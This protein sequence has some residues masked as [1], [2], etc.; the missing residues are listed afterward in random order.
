MLY[1]REDFDFI[2]AHCHFFPPQIFKAI[3]DFFEKTD[4]NGA[5]QGWSIKYKLSTK[6]L[7]SFLETHSVKAFTTYNYAHKK[8]VAKFINDFNLPCPQY[9]SCPQQNSSFITT[10]G[11]FSIL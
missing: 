11:S 4:E 2:D 7:V 1:T 5:L 6:E 3:W 8:G 9:I 10:I